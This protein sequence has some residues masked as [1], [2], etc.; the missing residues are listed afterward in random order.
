MLHQITEFITLFLI[1][2][3]WHASGITIGYHRLLSH[4]SFSLHSK[5]VEYF[6]VL[7][8]YLA[9]E[10]SPIWWATM[11][12]AHH[13]WVD[14]PLDPHSPRFGVANA[15]YGWL[16]G[17]SYPAHIDPAIQSKDLLADPIY[18]FLE[19]NGDWT[20][21]HIL[22]FSIGFLVRL[23]IFLCFGWI[24]ALAS[25][26]AGLAVLQ[27]PLMLN[28]AC[29]I[30]KLGY[31]T[32]ATTDDSVNVWWVGILALGEGWHNNHHACPGSAR[33]GMKFYEFDPS[34]LMICLMKK[35]G[36]VGR[37]NAP[38]HEQLMARCH[39]VNTAR[40]VNLSSGAHTALSELSTLA[41][42]AQSALSEFG[43][44][45]SSA[46]SAAFSEL[47]AVASNA[48]YAFSELSTAA[49]SNAQSALNKKTKPALSAR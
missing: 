38:T 4:R 12:R 46:H 8:G 47:S 49:A 28:V 31:K 19:Q 32:Y 30:P 21:A 18:R 39:G 23:G 35:L 2:Y 10:G 16:K 20:R 42:S 34:W 45:A 25:L 40:E 43:T 14:T 24:P 6:W 17:P 1:F 41:S 9:F 48:Q 15:H 5:L 7:A 13:R 11:H 37:I 36:L 22:G 33:S 29:H 44:A 26:L 27:I 3:V